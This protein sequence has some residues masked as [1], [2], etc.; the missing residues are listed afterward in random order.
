M[1]WKASLT[2]VVV[3]AIAG[4]AVGIAL[5]SKKTT[6]VT[7]RTVTVAR[8][9]TLAAKTSTTS[10]TTSTDTSTTTTS[11]G[12]PSGG[13]PST[14]SS[15]TGSEEYYATY[16]SSQDTEQLDSEA[17]DASLDDNPSSLELKGQTYQNAIAFDL[18]NEDSNTLES[19]QLPVPGFATFR[20]AIAGLDT[21]ASHKS[22]FKLTIYK[23]NDN[24]GATVLYSATFNGPS[25]THPITFNT[26]GATLLVFDW[27]EPASGEPD[28]GDEFI[29]ANPVVTR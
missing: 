13:K 3:V 1:N 24:A 19:Y 15:G 26:R 25:D 22:M 10:S 20:C 9:V 17:T 4:L 21:D 18:D 2:G 23:N 14:G 27:T 8:T 11:S 6:R 5:G 7:V 29:M 12:T 28:D 16:L